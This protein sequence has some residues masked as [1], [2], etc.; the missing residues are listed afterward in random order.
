M[1]KILSA[2]Q[3][4]ELDK[5]TIANEPVSSIDLMERASQ[6]FV[7]WF[8]EKFNAL[9][10][11]GVICGTGNNGGD[12]LAIARL[13]K[14]W[15][16]PVKV[17]IV[18][19]SVPATN[20]FKENLERLR[21]KIDLSEISSEADRNLFHDRDVLIDGLFGYG[22]SRPA[23]GIYAQVINCINATDALRVSI[24]MPSGLMADKPSTGP[25][26]KADY[27]VSFQLPKVSFFFPQ[28]YP[29]TGEWTLIDIGLNKHF[30]RDVKSTNF[31]ITGKGVKKLF[32]A[33]ERFDHK[34]TFGHAMLLAGSYGKIGAA[35][36]SGKSVLRSGAGLLTIYAPKCGYQIL[37]TALPEAMVMTDKS[38]E[39][40][41]DAPDMQHATVLGI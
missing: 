28:Y 26:V 34:G 27:T 18:Q 19:G 21:D 16:Y 23:E 4:R 40:L 36:L 2:E 33:R 1:I 17:W 31:Y 11:V 35:I 22:L 30:I 24:D 32:R 6:G 5:V 7:T 12:G 29:F 39:H 3:I 37:Q 20:D 25:I 10:K 41:S 9:N 8:T 15:G 13:L 14:E 38:E